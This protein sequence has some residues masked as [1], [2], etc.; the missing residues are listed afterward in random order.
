MEKRIFLWLCLLVLTGGL[1]R[2]IPAQN[3]LLIDPDSYYH[4]RIT[5]DIVESGKLPRW[6]YLSHA[7]EGRPADYPPLLHLVAATAYYP[8][9]EWVSL[10]EFTMLFGWAVGLLSAFAVYILAKKMYGAQTALFSTIVFLSM[11]IQIEWGS[12]GIFSAT[13]LGVG[14]SV[15]S[16]YFGYSAL[17][18]RNR[19]HALAYLVFSTLNFFIWR[20]W[21]LGIVPLILYA[22]LK[23]AGM[24]ENWKR[25][26]ALGLAVFLIGLILVVPETGDYVKDTLFE[27]NPLEDSVAQK[28]VPDI[29]RTVWKLSFLSLFSMGGL[30]IALKRRGAGDLLALALLSTT[31]VLLPQGYRYLLFFSIPLAILCGGFLGY[32]ASYKKPE[33]VAYF[34]LGYAL[35]SIFAYGFS[36]AIVLALLLLLILLR[37]V[38]MNMRGLAHGALI[39]LLAVG[40]MQ[41]YAT[42]KNLSPNIGSAKMKALHWIGENTE[43]GA[44]ILA[45]WDEGHYITAIGKRRVVMDNYFYYTDKVYTGKETERLK[46]RLGLYQRIYALQ[47]EQRQRKKAVYEKDIEVTRGWAELSEIEENRRDAAFKLRYL[48]PVEMEIARAEQKY[49]LIGDIESRMSE[50]SSEE[51][52]QG[53]SYKQ[54]KEA[55]KKAEAEFKREKA[56][57]RNESEFIN[58]LPELLHN[59]GK[60]EMPSGASTELRGIVGD[61]EKIRKETSARNSLTEARVE[62][63]RDFF[64]GNNESEGEATLREYEVDYVFVWGDLPEKLSGLYGKKLEKQELASKLENYEKAGV[65][66]EA[67]PN[68][69]IF[70]YRAGLN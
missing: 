63:F 26:V 32:L 67:Y 12:A 60:I 65:L 53:D 48:L 3:H 7:P 35:F 58:S 59:G 36:L 66:R 33:R 11:P 1:I 19:R 56:E 38:K 25:I 43:K 62:Q 8:F 13:M 28:T 70:R 46:E 9:A 61:I 31:A 27:K 68:T 39:F 15:V 22:A 47:Q 52:K 2:L 49:G 50:L 30:V 18:E 41:A 69:G 16:L 55:V 54:K 29:W 21:L 51:K 57:E 14:I 24:W 37:A 23:K 64:Y 4:Y 40:I 10:L 42:A 34:S 45:F 44:V 6:D 20:G 17:E 5:K